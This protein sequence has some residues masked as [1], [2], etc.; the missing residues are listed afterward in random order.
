LPILDTLDD[1]AQLRGLSPTELETLAGE[2]REKMIRTVQQTGGHLASSLGAVE[3]TLAL[4]RVMRSPHD[5]I[6][7]DTGHQAYAHKLLTGRR[8]RFQTL[9]QLDG[10]GGFPRRSESD[11]DVFDGGHAGTGVSIGVG[12]AFPIALEM[13]RSTF[14]SALRLRTL[15]LPVIGAVT[16]VRRPGA[17][18]GFIAG[19]AGV[20]VT[21]GALLVVYGALMVIHVCLCFCLPSMKVI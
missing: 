12:L 9:R 1:P 6:V 16:Y 11:H 5:R 15:G 8:D 18:R 10:V 13:V 3:L 21:F 2:L 14:S 7:W 19:A 4:H 17:T 20:A